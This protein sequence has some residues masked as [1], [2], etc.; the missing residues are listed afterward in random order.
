VGARA[1]GLAARSKGARARREAGPAFPVIEGKLAAP[2]QR[3]ELIRRHDLV[4]RLLASKASP[5][6]AVIAPAGYGKTTLLSQ[7]AEEGGRPVV[8]LSADERDNDPSV[9]LTYLAVGLDRIQPI[10]PKIFRE[11]GSP[12]PR[13][14]RPSF[15]A[16]WASWRATADR[17]CWSWTIS[18]S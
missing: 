12:S 15:L 14:C 17:C 10:R 1:G 7:W 3:S 8:W 18:I 16:W 9:L 13:S 11:L 2:P 5:V 4:E 6:V